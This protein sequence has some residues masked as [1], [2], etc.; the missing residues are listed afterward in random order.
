MSHRKEIVV[1]SV[2]LGHEIHIVSDKV[3]D[4]DGVQYHVLPLK[5]TKVSV[6]QDLKYFFGITIWMMKFK[7]DVVHAITIKPVLY[8]GLAA[9]LT[10]VRKVIVSISGLGQLFSG[11]QGLVSRLV[12]ALYFFLIWKSDVHFIFQNQGDY[13]TLSKVS[14]IRNASFTTGSGVDLAQFESIH[15]QFEGKKLRFLFA[16][17]LLYSKGVMDFFRAAELF[18]SRH[19]T[20]KAEFVIAG[21]HDPD[22]PDSLNSSDMNL[23]TKKSGIEFKGMVTNMP[24]LLKSCDVFVLPTSYGEGIP[25]ALLEAMAVG[26]PVIV[27]NADGCLAVVEHGRNG[28]VLDAPG[29]DPIYKALRWM[30]QNRNELTMM[31]I[32]NSEKAKQD[33]GVHN[34]VEHHMRLYGID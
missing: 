3:G 13:T 11:R 15:R 24:D 2:R 4:L 19:G 33:F 1:S 18:L 34:I 10:G 12:K 7:P 32:S 29:P 5:R 17:R 28:F 22:N 9:R 16:S 30:D 25:K 31:S 8:G 6:I 14:L 26:L 27:S 23:M 21:S 20:E